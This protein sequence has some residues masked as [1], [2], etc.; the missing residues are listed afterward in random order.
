MALSRMIAV[1]QICG[2]TREYSSE[3]E[4]LI[5]GL[6]FHLSEMKDIIRIIEK[7]SPHN[8]KNCAP[9]SITVKYSVVF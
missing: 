3:Y 1:V 8:Y 6:D 7:P 4:H 9:S 2:N 5:T